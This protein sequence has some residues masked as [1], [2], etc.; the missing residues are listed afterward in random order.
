MSE[1]GKQA[2]RR[3][4]AVTREE[5]CRR[6]RG[7]RMVGREEGNVGWRG[8]EKGGVV[9]EEEGRLV[10]EGWLRGEERMG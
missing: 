1:E 8:K 2:A 4:L 5:A 6:K 3:E 10:E 7:E 9:E